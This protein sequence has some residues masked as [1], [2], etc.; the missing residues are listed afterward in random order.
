MAV[1]TLNPLEQHAGKIF[2][3]LV[4]LVT[5]ILAWVYVFGDPVTVATRGAEKAVAEARQDIENQSRELGRKIAAG[6]EPV[7]TPV[8]PEPRLREFPLGSPSP[9]IRVALAPIGVPGDARQNAAIPPAVK[10]LPL[11]ASPLPAPEALP[12]VEADQCLLFTPNPADPK[13]PTE[14]Q[15]R[16]CTVAVKLP[17]ARL[18]SL[19]KEAREGAEKLNRPWPTEAHANQFLICAV[20][21]E[22]QEFDAAAQ[23][24]GSPQPVAAY[25]PP[26]WPDNPATKLPFP[27][28]G[29]PAR[30]GQWTKD[31]STLL[32]ALAAGQSNVLTPRLLGSVQPKVSTLIVPAPTVPA[33]PPVA[34]GPGGPVVP[35]PVPPSVAPPPDGVNGAAPPPP[36]GPGPVG[37][38]PVAMP[39]TAQ[40][41]AWVIDST[42]VAG[43]TYRYRVKYVA[44]SPLLNSYLADPKSARP[45]GVPDR[46]VVLIE[47]SFSDWSKPCSTARDWYVFAAKESPPTLEVWRNTH[48]RWFREEFEARIGE[49]VGDSR[50][51]DRPNNLPKVQV[52]FATPLR[53]VDIR[54]AVEVMARSKRDMPVER[55]TTVEIILADEQGRLQVRNARID[56]NSKDYNEKAMPKWREQIERDRIAASQPAVGG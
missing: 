9:L 43:R 3:G 19:L 34:P 10:F 32:S 6:T 24:V 21:A 23:P 38:P 54:A 11:L 48:S 53:V 2:L 16:Y 50:E 26:Q 14:V 17:T 8:Q 28:L 30:L 33:P 27:G 45:D 55:T 7:A 13:R 39:V 12:E 47:S 37:P 52:D 25:V 18:A 22:R 46:Y 42:V 31:M 35:S 36:V 29:D 5:L 40:P 41:H 1:R 51:K 20:L 15:F 44:I 56:M 49:V 4:V